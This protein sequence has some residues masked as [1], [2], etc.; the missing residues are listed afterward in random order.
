MPT[1]A[2]SRSRCDSPLQELHEGIDNGDRTDIGKV[3]LAHARDKARGR[4]DGSQIVLPVL[5]HP[6]RVDYHRRAQLAAWLLG[7]SRRGH[8]FAFALDLAADDKA[9]GN[10]YAGPRKV[11]N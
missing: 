2:G 7:K 11:E 10:D 1:S 8:S 6:D 5:V 9:R 3:L 4:R